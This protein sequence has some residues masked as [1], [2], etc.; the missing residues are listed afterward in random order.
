M[1]LVTASDTRRVKPQWPLWNSQA[2]D[3]YLQSCII[4]HGGRPQYRHLLFIWPVSY[5]M[6]NP[7]YIIPTVLKVKAK[8]RLFKKV[9]VSL[10]FR[11]N[12]LWNFILS[13]TRFIMSNWFFYGT[14][15]IILNWASYRW[16]PSKW[17]QLHK[18]ISILVALIT[19]KINNCCRTKNKYNLINAHGHYFL[20]HLQI[21]DH[22]KAF[23]FLTHFRWVG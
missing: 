18:I 16:W 15:F 13:N 20:S 2:S 8:K 19:R 11:E 6:A 9:I 7:I 17:I 10:T 23:L 3:Y 22:K 21:M 4:S 5:A 12:V 14:I 1:N